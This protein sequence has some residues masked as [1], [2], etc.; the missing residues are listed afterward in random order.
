MRG[1]DFLVSRIEETLE[2]KSQTRNFSVAVRLR[3]LKTNEK[4]SSNIRLDLPQNVVSIDANVAATRW[5]NGDGSTGKSIES[6]PQKRQS[7]LDFQYD[8][9]QVFP[10]T[11]IDKDKV[12]WWPSSREIHPLSEK[13][14]ESAQDDEAA[15][16]RGADPEDLQKQFF[17]KVA[18]QRIQ[19]V[20]Q[21]YNVSI[22]AYGQVD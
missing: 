14:S 19:D 21:G 12:W 2:Q 3:P 7:M 13:H 18:Q 15:L 20:F 17:E 10:Y 16:Q 5:S 22:L 6:D 9:V 4:T 1:F 11:C 8:Y